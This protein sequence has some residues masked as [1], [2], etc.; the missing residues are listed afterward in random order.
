MDSGGSGGGGTG[1]N[2]G[3][4]G[5]A[6]AIGSFDKASKA[7]CSGG[8]GLSVAAGGDPSSEESCNDSSPCAK[9]I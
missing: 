9:P 4:G 7:S 2:A 5:K 6:T 3:K 1:A 8:D